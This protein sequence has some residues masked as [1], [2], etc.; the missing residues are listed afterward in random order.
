MDPA[1]RPLAASPAAA[2]PAAVADRPGTSPQSA[3]LSPPQSQ[4][5]PEQQLTWALA[6][7]QAEVTAI[8]SP[9]LGAVA[10]AARPA[11]RG[12]LSWSARLGE[13]HGRSRL[14]VTLRH[15]AGAELSSETWAP[16][17]SD[18]ADT[19]GLLLAMLL[20]IPVSSQA[21][22]VKPC[23][24]EITVPASEP[25][26][27]QAPLAPP[28]Q[29]AGPD[30]QHRPG[31]AEPAPGNGTTVPAVDPGL[32]PLS[33]DEI[34][35]CHRRILA[36]PPNTRREFTNAFREHFAVPRNARSIGDRINQRQHGLF[37]EHFLAE[38]QSLN[39]SQEQGQGPSQSQSQGQTQTENPAQ[40]QV[41]AAEPLPLVP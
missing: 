7:F 35:D 2:V 26:A 17:A 38:A 32:E 39:P 10:A 25:A 6:H 31:G 11:L 12:G 5:A 4:Q 16:E 19:A 22:A 29:A 28:L 8:A 41:P 36:L 24:S 33:P 37:L 34:G 1:P 40:P 9:D 21:Q 23:D 14:Q 13:Q 20:G 15:T 18:L 30:P 3:L 27:A